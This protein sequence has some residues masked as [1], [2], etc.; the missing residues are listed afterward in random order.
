MSDSRI[1]LIA[2]LFQMQHGVC[3]IGEEPLDLAKDKLEID[4]I[5]PRAKG[6]KDDENNYALTCESCCLTHPE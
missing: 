2:K 3:F 5:V 4:H 6:G 1:Q